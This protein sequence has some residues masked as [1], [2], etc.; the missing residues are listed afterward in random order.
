MYKARSLMDFISS[1]LPHLISLPIRIPTWPGWPT[2]HQGYTIFFGHNLIAW[3][4]K[5]QAIVSRSSTE[6]EY[7]AL[8]DASSEFIWIERLLEERGTLH[9]SPPKLWCDNIGAAYLYASPVFHA[10]TRHVKIN[11][12]LIHERVAQIFHH[13]QISI[14]GHLHQASTSTSSEAV[15]M[16]SKHANDA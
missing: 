12:H 16:Q 5:E 1:F 13:L 9:E 7:K 10:P 14:R 15:Q 3:K 4:P 8:F 6:F 11:F 2:V